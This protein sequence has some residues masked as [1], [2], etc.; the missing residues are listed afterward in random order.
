MK[1]ALIIAS[2]ITLWLLVLLG[3]YALVI[4]VALKTFYQNKGYSILTFGVTIM[5][6]ETYEAY[7]DTNI[8]QLEEI[9]N[10]KLNKALNCANNQVLSLEHLTAKIFHLNAIKPIA[11]ITLTKR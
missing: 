2:K 4:F 11:P 3:V 8:K 7:L 6:E 9:R 1:K 5:T 10:Q